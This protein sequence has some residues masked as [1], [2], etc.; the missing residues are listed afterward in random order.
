V[1][2]QPELGTLGDSLAA[3]GSDAEAFF[4]R[5]EA[6]LA[7]LPRPERWDHPDRDHFWAKLPGSLREGAQALVQRVLQL[8]GAIADGVRNAPL[9]SEADQRD[10]MTSAKA[11]RAALLLRQFHSWTRIC[12]TWGKSSLGV[13][14]ILR[15]AD[16]EQQVLLQRRPT[17]GSSRPAEPA[18]ERRRLAAKRRERRMRR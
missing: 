17:C 5:A 16:R 2:D 10:V 12:E 7:T 15:I 6:A 11:M 4:D 9:A 3:L 18:A 8:A 13:L 14:S 1:T